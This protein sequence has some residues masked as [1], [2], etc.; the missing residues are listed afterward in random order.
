MGDYQKRFRDGKFGDLRNGGDENPVREF[1]SFY[2]FY[3]FAANLCSA[4]KNLASK[5]SLTFE[6][7][8]GLPVGNTLPE[9]RRTH[10]G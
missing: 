3:E 9:N 7:L 6:F 5:V 4:S 1:L 2:V 8:N 10:D